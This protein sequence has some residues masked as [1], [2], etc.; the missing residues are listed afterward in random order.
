MANPSYVD[1]S[2]DPSKRGYGSLF[3]ERPDLMNFQYIGFGRLVTAPAWLSTW[4]GLSSNADFAKNVSRIQTPMLFVNALRDKEIFPREAKAMYDACRSP[5]RSFIEID[6][7][8]Y[9]EPEFGATHAPDVDTLM[10]HVVPW[11]TER[12]A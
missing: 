12:F 1:H 5:D 11:I 8:H 4:S 6:A 3:S 9:F 7:E 10:S 2:I